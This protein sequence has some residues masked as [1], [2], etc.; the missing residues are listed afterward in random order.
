[1]HYYAFEM[2]LLLALQFSIIYLIILLTF[3]HLTNHSLEKV[4]REEIGKEKREEE[5]RKIDAEADV[6]IVAERKR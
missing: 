6:K 1:M 3:I 5:E 2:L 4:K